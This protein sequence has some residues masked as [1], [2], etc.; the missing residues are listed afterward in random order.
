M[1]RRE[2]EGGRTKKTLL[3][4]LSKSVRLKTVTEM[5]R[6]QLTALDYSTHTHTH[7]HTH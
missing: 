1:L 6:N 5:K 2:R 7:T 3:A 4:S